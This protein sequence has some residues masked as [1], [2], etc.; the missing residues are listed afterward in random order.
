MSSTASLKVRRGSHLEAKLSPHTAE[1]PGAGKTQMT[2]P[3]VQHDQSQASD[4]TVHSAQLCSAPANERSHS[5]SI[6]L[7]R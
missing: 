5:I 6:S 2:A 4:L 7:W 1:G 3:R